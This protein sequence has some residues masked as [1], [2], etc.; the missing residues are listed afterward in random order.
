M[1]QWGGGGGGQEF[2]S[3]AENFVSSES[4]K[5]EKIPSLAYITFH[6]NNH[7]LTFQALS[8]QSFQ[9]TLADLKRYEVRGKVVLFNVCPRAMAMCPSTRTCK[10]RMMGIIRARGDYWTG[11][12]PGPDILIGRIFFFHSP[13]ETLPVLV[14][15]L[16]A[17][18]FSAI[19][20][21]PNW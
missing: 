14:N 5:L 11:S 19:Y 15:A 13:L 2:W 16:M 10:I 17:P 8:I 4:Q 21:L 9:T 18:V 6:S 3:G 20:H 7:F 12:R 1:A